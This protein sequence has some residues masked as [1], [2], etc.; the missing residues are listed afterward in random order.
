MQE[1]LRHEK[2]ID[3]PIKKEQP[4][5]IKAFEYYVSLDKRSYRA[6]AKKFT[7]SETSIKKWAKAFHWQDKLAE[8]IPERAKKL[9]A[10]LDEKINERDVRNIKIAE[11]AIKVFAQSLIGYVEFTC[12]CGKV[13]QIPIPKAKITADHFDKMVR[14]VNHLLGEEEEKAGTVININLLGVDPK[15]RQV[16]SEVIDG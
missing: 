8:R 16:E 2:A 11:G 7:V 14:L 10:K 6:V 15:P 1:T 3:K 4:R 12:E 13:S 5:H 9:A